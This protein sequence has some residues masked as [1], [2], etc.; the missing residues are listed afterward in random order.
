MP[1]Y[2]E[3]TITVPRDRPTAGLPDL[4][5]HPDQATDLA[6]E[7][8]NRAPAGGRRRAE[9]GAVPGWTEAGVGADRDA[10]A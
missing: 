9:L 5:D 8:F 4:L 3:G 10:M 7:E 6:I 2:L 1:R